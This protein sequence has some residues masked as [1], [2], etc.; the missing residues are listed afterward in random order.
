MSNRCLSSLLPANLAHPG[1]SERGV[2]CL[3]LAAAFAA[4][5]TMAPGASARPQDMQVTVQ[6]TSPL[7]AASL[8]KGDQIT[9]QVAR[10]DSFKG[11]SIRGHV[12]QV[13]SG[14]G[15]SMVELTF[16]NLTHAGVI[17][18]VSANIQGV[19]NSQG[20]PGMDD[21]GR[22]VQSSNVAPKQP[23]QSRL[24]SRLGG[25]LGGLIG[26]RT[27]EVASDAST[28]AQGNG[29]SSAGAPA[30]IQV[31]AQGGLTLG[32]GSTLTLSLRSN[33]G[34]S[35]AS[36]AP[37][38]SA[39]AVAATPSSPTAPTASAS[40]AASAPPS[41]P[42]ASAQPIAAGASPGGQPELKATKIEFIPGERTVFFDDFSD[43][44][45]DEP[46]PHW[47]VREG[48]VDLLTGGGIRELHADK[49][50]QL[51]S[52]SF[53]IPVNFTFELVWTGRGEMSWHFRDKDNRDV[54]VATVRGEESGQEAN[55][56]VSGP[57]GGLG[58][59]GI[60]VDTSQP[61]TFALWAQQ[62]R[63]RAYINGQR[64]V[65]TNQVMFGPMDN[66]YANFAGYR[67]NGMRS[68]RIAESAPDFST[69]I[70]ASGKYVTHG[71]NFDTDSDH[72]KSESS[73][74]LKQ[75]AAGLAKNPNLKLEID[76]YTD[77]VGDAAHNLD[78]S[79]RRALAVQ[80]VL[81]SQFGVDADRLTSNG[82]GPAKPIGSND[83]PD[84]RA[85][86]RR[87]EFL[88]K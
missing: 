72:L 83:T 71:I 33:G 40:N 9:A 51:T 30:L 13:N 14:R 31:A 26:G 84:G 4:I 43:M 41:A 39:P 82:F 50:V 12:T 22:P 54:L 16:D 48:T 81:V 35:L 45:E 21:Q 32:P 60:P 7:N 5:L 58:G 86:N 76:G 64:L 56:S 77:S 27:G 28:D 25:Q 80:T 17:V 2:R 34:Q 47:K 63:V 57:D 42:T 11:D 74:V 19:S 69:V 59:G 62:G 66:V 85:A 44:V 65:D 36:L 20:Q 6:L 3:I 78:L 15:Q 53:V 37:N 18:A 23:S 70:N 61:V 87:V 88:K 79:K 67:P 38:A 55:V 49:D 24:G 75:V 52:P 68:F 10:P 46:P 29:N 1:N 8:H 73:A